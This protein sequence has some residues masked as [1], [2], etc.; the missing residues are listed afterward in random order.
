MNPLAISIRRILES[1]LL[2]TP[3]KGNDHTSVRP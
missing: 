1:A 2:A 3:D